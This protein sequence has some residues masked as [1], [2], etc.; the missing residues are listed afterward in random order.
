MPLDI[1][2]IL[3]FE[4]GYRMIVNIQFSGQLYFS[5]FNL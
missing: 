4:L 2:I 5:D 1:V 3:I